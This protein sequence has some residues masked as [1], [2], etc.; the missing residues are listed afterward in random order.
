MNPQDSFGSCPKL[1]I[2]L[3]GAYMM[4]YNPTPA[5]LAF[6]ASAHESCTALIT[7]C[8]GMLAAQL[9]G[10]LDGKTATAPRFMIA[11]LQKQDPRTTWVEK[12]FVRD[13]KVWTSGALL[14]GL[15]LMREF[16]RTYW[17]ELAEVSVRI[18]GLPIRDVDYVGSDGMLMV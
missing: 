3:M 11:E 4:G 9:S 10:V 16:M 8:G 5:E 12:R 17:P 14:N 18:G 6:I 7:I 2:V 1:D 15:D 13:G